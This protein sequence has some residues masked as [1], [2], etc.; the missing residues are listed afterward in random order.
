MLKPL[1]T[2]PLE[3]QQH[4]RV[5]IE[6][7]DAGQQNRCED[8]LHRLIERLNKSSLSYGGRQPSREEL[9]ERDHHV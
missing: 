6:T 8:A 9:H 2:L 4:V 5:T 7:V 1:E 3:E